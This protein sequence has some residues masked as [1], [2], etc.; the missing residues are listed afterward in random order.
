MGGI[1]S[2]AVNLVARL[3]AQHL[4]LFDPDTVQPENIAPGF[5]TVQDIEDEKPF[6]VMNA[7][8][9]NLD[10]AQHINAQPYE[11]MGQE[12]ASDV[13]IISTDSMISRRDAWGWQ[14]RLGP[15]RLWIDCRMGGD[16]ASLYVV[17]RPDERDHPDARKVYREYLRDYEKSLRLPDTP[18]PCGLKSTAALTV[19]MI[20]GM[21]GTVLYRAVWGQLPPKHLFYKMSA[22]WWTVVESTY[23]RKDE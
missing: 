14:E 4:T 10:L 8:D 6:S 20:P 2:N 17:Y 7:I 11:Y 19:G 21:I 18:L 16:Q 15:W 1:G 13:V 3:G 22:A 5:F 9:S 23:V 12:I